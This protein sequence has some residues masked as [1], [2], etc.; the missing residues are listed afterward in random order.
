MMYEQGLIPL[1][2]II[3]CV[4]FVANIILIN[5]IQILPAAEDI[6][7]PLTTKEAIHD[8]KQ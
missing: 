6:N 2:T 5:W 3:L 8:K 1:V 7:D 4:A